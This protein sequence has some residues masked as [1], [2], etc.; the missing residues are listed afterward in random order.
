[1]VFIVL[2]V[3][4][5]RSESKYDARASGKHKELWK[6][7][8]DARPGRYAV[9]AVTA[10]AQPNKTLVCCDD[11]KARPFH[12][13][14]P[15]TKSIFVSLIS[16][17]VPYTVVISLFCLFLCG[18]PY[19]TKIKKIYFASLVSLDRWSTGYD[20]RE[21]SLGH[22][23]AQTRSNDQVGLARARQTVE[24]CHGW[25]RSGPV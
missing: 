10:P 19:M 21:R 1:M 24:L 16:L 3:F 25:T 2:S 17:A 8:W 12:H 5:P 14:R 11:P 7:R 15:W 6:V 23:V 20:M 9:P 13:V 4:L 18:V 22:A